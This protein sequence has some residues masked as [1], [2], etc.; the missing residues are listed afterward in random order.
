MNPLL[1][2]PNMCPVRCTSCVDLISDVRRPYL[3]KVKVWGEPP[4]KFTRFYDITA[5]T[6]RAA[7]MKGLEL[8]MKEFSPA[9]RDPEL[10]SHAPKAKLD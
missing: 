9:L 8:F 5:D 3:F 1:I 4:H 2:D 7:G 6:D 10:V